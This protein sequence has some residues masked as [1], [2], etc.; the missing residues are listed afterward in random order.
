M[1]SIYLAVSLRL[2]SQ[3]VSDCRVRLEFH[4]FKLTGKLRGEG[5]LKISFKEPLD[6]PLLAL[7]PGF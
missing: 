2:D 5:Y 7:L 6:D 1:S 3:P 4:I